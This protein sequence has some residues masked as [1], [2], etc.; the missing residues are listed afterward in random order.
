LTVA[1][2]DRL[3]RGNAVNL[4]LA[5]PLAALLL[6]TGFP[7]AAGP[8]AIRADLA[9]ID[10]E[11]AELGRVHLAQ[12]DAG[13]LA[14]IELRLGQVAD[15]LRRVTGRL[16]EVEFQ[17][18]TAADR[19]DRLVADVDRRLTALE[20]RGVAAPDLPSLEADPPVAEARPAPRVPQAP[21]TGERQLPPEGQLAPAER[22]LGTIRPEALLG[23]P[24]PDPDADAA[25]APTSPAPPAEVAALGPQEQ[26]D[27][28]LGLLRAGDYG[29]AERA[30][31]GLI[32]GHPDS[33]LAASAAYWIAEAHFVREDYTSAAAQ[34][35]R[36]FSSYGPEAPRAADNLLKLGMSLNAL[37]D[38]ERACQTYD[39]LQR[40]YPDAATPI[41]QAL[42]RERGRA[43]C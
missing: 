3:N 5:A 26:Y 18:R 8:A 24:L 33:E 1:R 23:L 12:A 20:E 34:F 32:D 15:E 17:Q 6:L 41:Q 25:A 9:A 40:R 30:F 43:G 28:G 36:N 13:R 31:S 10:R 11:I 27:R 42:A 16:E 19:I 2:P 37:G 39:E 4:L 35:A 7:A 29:E 21:A 14:D 22:Q 38:R